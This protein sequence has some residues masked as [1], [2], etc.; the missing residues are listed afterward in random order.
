MMAVS[1]TKAKRSSG[2]DRHVRTLIALIDELLPVVAEEN[3]SSPRAC[4][5][6]G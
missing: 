6:R 1:G 3:R 4:P 2:N 5:H